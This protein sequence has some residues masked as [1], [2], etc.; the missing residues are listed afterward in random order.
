MLYFAFN[1]LILGAIAMALL[2][3]FRRSL[4]PKYAPIPG[5]LDQKVPVSTTPL[6]IN[7]SFMSN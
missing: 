6:K 4:F 1:A 2:F 3:I 7:S 5:W